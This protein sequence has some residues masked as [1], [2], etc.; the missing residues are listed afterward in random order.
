MELDEYYTNLHMSLLLNL[1]PE[2]VI[3]VLEDTNSVGPTGGNQSRIRYNMAELLK[4]S[5]QIEIDIQ[6]SASS[7]AS[8]SKMNVNMRMM[9][10]QINSQSYRE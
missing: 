2:R 5:Q 9:S 1:E 10:K 6:D 4:T 3:P 8:K 7:S